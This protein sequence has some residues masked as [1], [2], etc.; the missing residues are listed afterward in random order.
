MRVRV[1]H[2]A[3]LSAAYFSEGPGP[4]LRDVFAYDHPVPD[5]ET[6]TDRLA[7]LEG[8]FLVFNVGDDPAFGIPESVAV[9]YRDRQ[10]RSLSTGDVIALDDD[11]Y[12]CARVGWQRWDT[13]SNIA[14]TAL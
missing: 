14:G 9:A 5:T 4:G 3:D 12:V 6:G 1:F 10:L 2:T 8:L 11:F 7:I 13:P